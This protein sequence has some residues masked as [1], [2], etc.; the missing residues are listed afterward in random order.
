MAKGKTIEDISGTPHICLVAETVLPC[1]YKWVVGYS[2]A[3]DWW[4]EDSQ[5]SSTILYYT[6]KLAV[7]WTMPSGQTGLT[8]TSNALMSC[9]MAI[10]GLCNVIIN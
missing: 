5:A 1:P 2:H 7:L 10:Y 9:Y 6:A 8:T 4:L 3:A